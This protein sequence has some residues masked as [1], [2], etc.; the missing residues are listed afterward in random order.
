MLKSTHSPTESMDDQK[1]HKRKLAFD[2]F[3]ESVL[4]ADHE[5]RQ[6]S[7]DQLCYHELMEWRENILHY[8]DKRRVDEFY[9]HGST[10]GRDHWDS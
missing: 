8:L 9:N 3:Y 6:S 2:L 7:H 1:R 4:K 10:G 5:L